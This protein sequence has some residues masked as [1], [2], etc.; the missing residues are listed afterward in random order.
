MKFKVKDLDIST[1][2]VFIAVINK[3]D[4]Q[5][6]DLR[7][8]ERIIIK[9]GRKKVVTAI[10][11]TESRKIVPQGR[12][13]LYRELEDSSGFRENDEV[14]IFISQYPQSLTYIKKKLRGERLSQQ[15]F[16]EIIRDI[17]CN[18]LTKVEITYF[19]SACYIHEPSI[20]ETIYLTNA[21]L[22]TGETIKFDEYPIVDKH[23]VGGVAGNRTTM[24]VVPIVTAAGLTMPKTSSRSI[25]SPAGTADTMEVLA[26]V[27]LTIPELKKVVAKTGGCMVWGGTLNLAP[28]DDIII[29]VEHEVSLDPKGQLLAS[30]LAKKKSVSTTHLL[31][32]IPMGQPAKIKTMKE[33]LYLKKR[34]ETV[35]R[36]LGLTIKV[37][38]TDGREPI[39]RG[40]GPALE[41]RDVLWVLKNGPNAPQD[42]RKKSLFLAGKIFELAGR[43]AKGD[44]KKYAEAI[45]NS[46]KAYNKFVEIVNA[47]GGK[48][49]QP[50][51]LKIGKLSYIVKA[52]KEGKIRHISNSKISRIAKVAGA[53]NDK[54]AGV[55]LHTLFGQRVKKGDRLFTVY[56]NSR[57]KMKFVKKVL[58]EI[59]VVDIR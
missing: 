28:A 14:T 46:G 12:I 54:G 44:G 10:D 50:E 16:D 20:N 9:K 56:S 31:I 13:G 36:A 6:L 4:A 32:D 21:I 55:Y 43:C 27:S 18:Q 47:Q 51:K 23:C 34:F 29:R 19:V 53:P 59:E 8:G 41:A 37:V 25:T 11:I 58:N 1:G 33:A 26:P 48:E 15:E 38:I 35:G 3:A 7:S 2:D 52:G 24:I 22:R 30:I 40:I 17:V 57:E 39:G 5:K 45:L 42:L 49:V